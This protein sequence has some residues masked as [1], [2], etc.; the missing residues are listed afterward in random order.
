MTSLLDILV[1]PSQEHLL[2]LSASQGVKFDFLVKV[3]GGPSQ[4]QRLTKLKVVMNY[5]MKSEN[6]LEGDLNFKAWK[7]KTDLILSKNKVLYI[8]KGNIM[9]PQF[10]EGKE[11][12][13]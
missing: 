13:P 8:V 11:K 5:S 2:L 10:E 7:K 6:K 9:E 12:E 3:K 4:I 1:C